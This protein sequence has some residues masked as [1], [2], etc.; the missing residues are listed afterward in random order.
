MSEAANDLWNGAMEPFRPL[1]NTVPVGGLTFGDGRLALIA[2]PCAIESEE[3]CLSVAEHLAALCG[4]MD[5]P[6]VF[7][8]SFDKANRTSTTSF[9]GHGRENGLAVLQKVKEQVGVP[10][11]TDVHETGQ[12]KAASEVVD[13]LQI[14]A[15]LCRQTDLLVECGKWGK[16]VNIK[17]GQFL[18]PEDM[19]Y[20]IDK[21]LT[22]GNRN[23]LS[24]ERGALL[25]YRDLVV[26]MRGLVI[27]RSL[28]YPVVFDATHSVQ[29]MGGRGGVSG[30]KTEF[31][32][33]QV[34]GA[35]AVGVDALFIET[36]PDPESALSDG[37][38]MVPLTHMRALL[39]MAL[40]VHAT[41][42]GP[43]G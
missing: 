2:G 18:P 32:P 14:P 5:V 6:Y 33:A 22:T 42:G 1:A 8:S 39:E 26:D 10:T 37:S 23:V 9:R 38:T 16:A 27:M 12:V 20:A 31:I 21:V 36:H 29:Q 35:I 43:R 11:L 40:A 4:E 3:L 19:K 28:G 30:G 25:G 7:K 24:T 41:H 17:K 15:F 34:R 13:I